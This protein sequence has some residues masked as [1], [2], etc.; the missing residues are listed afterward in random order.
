MRLLLQLS[1][2]AAD[3]GT[4]LERADDGSSIMQWRMLFVKRVVHR[5]RRAV[6]SRGLRHWFVWML[7][8]HAL[9]A[10]DGLADFHADSR[11]NGRTNG[12]AIR[13]A[14]GLA[15]GAADIDSDGRAN[16]DADGDAN[17]CAFVAA[18][19][20]AHVRAIDVANDAP[21]AASDNSP[22]VP[23]DPTAVDGGVFDCI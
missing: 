21:D 18:F 13:V 23:T 4:L 9:Y 2:A 12:R 10:S 1:L 19:T 20:C 11:A 16:S 17:S 7:R 15:D 22:D 3:D 6:R 14:I 8:E 5:R